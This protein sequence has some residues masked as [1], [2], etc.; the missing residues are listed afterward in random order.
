MPTVTLDKPIPPNDKPIVNEWDEKKPVAKEEVKPVAE[1]TAEE[2][3]DKQKA[4]REEARKKFK[5]IDNAKYELASDYFEYPFEE[6]E[7]GQGFF[8][9]LES[10]VTMDKLVHSTNK[11]ANMFSVQ[12]SNIERNEEGDEILENL[13][14]RAR[15]RNP[16]GSFQVDSG[17][18]PKLTSTA[19]TR[20]KLIGPRFMVRAV[21]KDDEVSEN[22]KAEADGVLVIR[23]D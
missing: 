7:V 11:Q 13:T 16:D 10:N 18:Q 19:L 22:N 23:V 9:P 14:V 5:I 1:P 3:E 6:L 17:G 21:N 8:V 15:L 20:P 12:N 2:L 4:D